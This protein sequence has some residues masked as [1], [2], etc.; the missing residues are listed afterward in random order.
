MSF[1]L[2]EGACE[3]ITGLWIAGEKQT[4]K[5][6]SNGILTVTKGKYAGHVVVYPVLDADGTTDSLG[7]VA[8]RGAND[9]WSDRHNFVDYSGVI[10]KLTQGD[11][12]EP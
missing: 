5:I 3:A 12:N 8:M 4:V 1:L 9:E 10:V 7:E 11:R 2:S 6:D